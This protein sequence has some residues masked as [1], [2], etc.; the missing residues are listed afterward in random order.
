MTSF[1]SQPRV[2]ISYARSD[3]EAS[4][5]SLRQRLEREH[6]EI[7]LW[8]DRVRMQGGVGWWRQIRDALEV[9]EYLVLV[10]T[11]SAVQSEICQRE[12]RYARQHGACVI[13]VKAQEGEGINFDTIPRWMRK[14]HFYDLDFE[15][16]VFI[17][18]LKSPCQSPRIPF[19]PP[20]LPQKLVERPEIERVVLRILLAEHAEAEAAPHLALRGP[21][22]IGKTTVAIAVCHNDD[23][24]TLYDDGILWV[25]LGEQPQIQQTLTKLYAAITGERP[26]F[27][28]E[29][30]AAYHLADRLSGLHCLLVIDDVWN[31][32]HLSP[33]LRGGEGVSR[34]ATTRFFDVAAEMNL[35]DVGEMTIGQSERMLTQRFRDL[36]IDRGRVHELADRIDR[37]PLLLELA[38]SAM[39]NRIKRGDTP[40]NALSYVSR[41][42]DK[43]GVTAFDHHTPSARH[44]A[45]ASTIDASLDL[46]EDVER[47]RL[48]ELAVFPEDVSI[49]IEAASAIW[50]LDQWDTEELVEQFE[51][52][53]LLKFFPQRAELQLHDLVRQYLGVLIGDVGELHGL[54]AE[55]LADADDKLREYRVRWLPYHLAGARRFVELRS[56]LLSIDW[57][58]EKIAVVGPA[59]TVDDFS[60][61]QHDPEFQLL[62]ETIRISAYVTAQDPDQLPSQLLARLPEQDPLSQ[63]LRRLCSDHSIPAWLVPLRPMLSRPGSPLVAT[64]TG[65]AGRVKAVAFGPDPSI[66]VSGSDDGSIRVWDIGRGIQLKE[67]T[68][69][70]DWVRDVCVFADGQH[71]VSVSDD[72]TIRVWDLNNFSC[73]RVIDTVF[74][75]LR[76]VVVDPEGR[77]VYTA[78]DSERIKKW[79]LES[80]EQV[81]TLIGHTAKVNELLALRDGRIIS[82]SDDRSVR[83][84]DCDSDETVGKFVEHSGRVVACA[85]NF[86]ETLMFTAG[87]DNKIRCWTL[88]EECGIDVRTVTDK[89]QW[90][91]D[92]A[93]TVDGQSAIS[94]AEDRELNVWDL[95]TGKCT[96][97]LPGHT[98]WIGAVAVS[99]DGKYI[100][101]A[102]DDHTLKIWHLGNRLKRDEEA[103]EHKGVIRQLACSVDGR[104]VFSIGDDRRLVVWTLGTGERIASFK[105]LDIHRLV[106][107]ADGER[108]VCAEGDAVIRVR[109]THNLHVYCKFWRHADRVRAITVSKDGSLVASSGDDRRVRIWQTADADQVA[110]FPVGTHITALLFL[111]DSKSLI[112]AAVSGRIKLLHAAT[113]EIISDFDGHTA[114]VNALA[115]DQRHRRFFSAAD[116]H[117]VRIWDLDT[118]T[119]LQ[120]L[121]GHAGPVR[122]VAILGDWVVSVAED[123]TLRVWD[124]TTGR[125]L[126][127]YTGESPF[128]AVRWSDD[129]RRIVAG[130]RQG[131][132][133]FLEPR[134][135][136]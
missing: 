56:L 118:K 10:M 120:V 106:P 58:R 69:H 26:A 5:Y 9:V 51:N 61:S 128:T 2:F 77:F 123:A 87:S 19:M 59:L 30:D 131:R 1:I 49:P 17:N 135:A 132:V 102:S 73:L 107:S 91:R 53:S 117:T 47:Q 83:F 97:R 33:F 29:E 105:N 57:L 7:T 99:P 16:D 50:Q 93:V 6:P 136:P 71:A 109:G 66:V 85:V 39:A 41:K 111:D 11:P 44:Q 89:A 37:W 112:S 42:L 27:V 79:D 75:W 116:D 62:A 20:D 4:A 124:D 54:M 92:L 134:I 28:D 38:G 84:W 70:Q 86:D 64:L 127:V 113:G 110:A 108:V 63:S 101:S 82:I 130:D 94:A 88:A 104:T 45:V 14:S 31:P 48:M 80:G 8:Q 98:D 115:L 126:A 90:V 52:L 36:A 25:T 3:G 95:A 81:G 67:L 15:W 96:A 21:G 125:P 46:I 24:I 32:A 121:N 78:D 114:K 13:P 72:H 40:E 65:H 18:T 133:H 68:G 22:G 76:V 129:G 103:T 43:H 74:D 122:D 35:I 100:V 23:V 55:Q 12:W 60:L 34:I 119:C